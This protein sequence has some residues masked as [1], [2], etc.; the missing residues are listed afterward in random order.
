MTL[1]K[2]SLWPPV[3]CL[4]AVALLSTNPFRPGFAGGQV[5]VIRGPYLQDVGVVDITIVWQTSVAVAGGVRYG[6]TPGPPWDFNA[7]NPTPSNLHVFRLQNLVPDAGYSYQL[8]ADGAALSGLDSFRTYPPTNSTKPFRFIAWGDSGT[9]DGLQLNVSTSLSQ[10]STPAD[11][12]LGLGD[13]VYPSGELEDYDPNFFKPYVSL[14]RQSLLWTAI[15]N[16]DVGTGSAA[17][18]LANFYLPTDTGAP[19]HPSGSERY[20]SF[21]HGLT[22]FV[23]IDSVDNITVGDEQY[24][25]ISDDLDDATARGMR[26][27]IV[28]THKP[29]YTKGTHDS[30]VENDL[31]ALQANLVPLTESKGVDL[32]LSGHSHNYE[33]SYLAA[34]G[35]VLQSHPSDYTKVGTIGTIYV[36]SGC[37]GKSGMGPFGHPLMAYSVGQ[38]TG[39]SVFDVTYNEIHGYFMEPDYNARDLFVLRKAP[40]TIAPRVT[41]VTVEGS[42]NDQLHVT[43]SEP[44]QGGAGTSGAE[45]V[46]NYI[47][48]GGTTVNSATLQSEART[49]VLQTSAFTVGSA[50]ILFVRNITDLASTPNTVAGTTLSFDLPPTTG[51]PENDTWRY[52]KGTSFPGATWNTVGYDDASWFV[53]QTGIGYGNGNNNTLLNDMQGNYLT[54]YARRVFNLPDAGSATNLALRMSYDDGFVAF[55]NGVEVARGNVSVG[56]NENTPADGSHGAEG[57]ELYDI[58][59]YLGLLGD[60]NNVL[61][62]EGHNYTSNDFSLHPVLEIVGQ[63]PAGQQAPTAVLAS[64]VQSANAPANVTFDTTSSIDPD[65]TIQNTLLLFGDTTLPSSN[66][67]VAHTYNDPGL[68]T[69]TLIVTDDQGLQSVAEQ[70]VYVHATGLPPTAI[71]NVNTEAPETGAPVAFD[72]TGSHDPDGGDVSIHWNFDDPASGA[73]NTSQE[74]SPTHTYTFPGSYAVTV[75]VTDD[76]GSQTGQTRNVNIGG[77][78]PPVAGDGAGCSLS[79]GAARSADPALLAIF[80]C[81]FGLL[82]WNAN[83]LRRRLN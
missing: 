41:S 37:G 66:A 14:M 29:P 17:P 19:G 56:Q 80:L 73:A 34:G 5:S 75:L 48:A 71:L 43:F 79:V 27:K 46:S 78:P 35:S 31:I 81:T 13:L 24:N 60:G 1:I 77:N 45:N 67:V 28:Y 39:V 54:V 63:D 21:D 4:A 68:Y 16:H 8:T 74:V 50:Y 6:R 7:T 32:F 44:M 23:C 72:A 59:G 15:G 33:R 69:A 49:V 11:L 36:V 65:G 12:Y 42:N 58:S 30:D 47:F 22:H 51:V 20:Y 53:G 55:I 38:T 70:G 25:W 64:D 9:G 82:I 18:Y 10:L 76:E 40:D 57:F 3:L 83:R 26:W 61:A 62:V 52:F 2:K